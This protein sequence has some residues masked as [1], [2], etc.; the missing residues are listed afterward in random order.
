MSRSLSSRMLL[1]ICGALIILLGAL[2]VIQH[3]WSLRVAAADLEREKEH[4]DSAASL[5][6]SQFNELTSQA[7]QFLR[8]DA[9]P[10]VQRGEKLASRPK[11]IGEL[12]YLENP[13]R[14]PAR[15]QRLN[16]TGSFVP[17]AQPDWL[18]ASACA[19]LVIDWPPAIVAHSYDSP[20]TE[21]VPG[22][23][24]HDLRHISTGK[25]VCFIARFDPTYLSATLF[26][27]LLRESFGETAVREYDFAVII[28]DR[29]H[30]PLYGTHMRP[31]LRK[32]FF[33][34]LATLPPDHSLVLRNTAEAFMKGHPDG[35]AGWNRGIWELEIT[36]KG[37]PLAT[38]F[39][40]KSRR[41]LLF[42][43]GLELL[44]VASIV[45][46]IVGS[47]RIQRVADQ[48]MRFV[49]G[50]SHELR[51]PV[52]AISML[53]RNQAD[54]LASGP[55]RVKQYGELIH[56]QARRLND[57]IEHSLQYAEV[58]SGLPRRVHE[59]VDVRTLV[60]EA[61]EERRA[62]LERSGIEVETAISEDLPP[63]SGDAKLLRT[64]VDN[65]L[66]NAG[67]HAA[68]GRWI[69]VTTRYS[70]AE[71]EVQVAVEDR[72][73]GIEPADEHE[74]FE[75][76]SR[77]RAAVETHAPGSGLGLS[78][79][80]SAVQAHR[81]DVTLASEPGRGSTFTLHLPV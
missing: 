69:R 67:K 52:A 9:W 25:D 13:N 41:V 2:T 45:F 46:L 32:R 15:W 66:D 68:T 8:H 57:M 79:V 49:A 39:K 1:A 58:H 35:P 30:N 4:L 3:R 23:A 60:R 61:V 47:R 5:F 74:I 7:T 40:Q 28:P 20:P 48:K 18:T 42:S 14:G 75:P 34:A 10:T 17:T 72:G 31:D 59:Q 21:R 80:R 65:L 78:L 24:P 29:P 22:D 63:L 77:G 16:A 55:D 76:F 64:A 50:I 73:A 43:L 54:G 71:K 53:S 12:Y 38:A 70:S 51:T 26:P 44:L 36:H 37:T 6:S 56:Q 19:G 11:L 81:G 33:S 27:Q 62:E